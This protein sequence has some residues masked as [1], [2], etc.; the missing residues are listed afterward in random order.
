[1]KLSTTH[2]AAFGMLAAALIA[3]R[4]ALVVV[5]V[6]D[7]PLAQIPE[8]LGPWTCTEQEAPNA[9][10]TDETV[11]LRRVYEHEDGTLISAGFQITSSRLGA[12]RNWSVAQMGNGWN[13]EEPSIVGPIAVEGLPFDLRL[14]LQWLHRTGLRRL[15]ATWFVSPRSQAVEYERAQ[16]H[17]WWD[18][19][20]GKCVWGE[21]YMTTLDGDSA[22][23]LERATR[24]LATRLAPHFHAA[25]SGTAAATGATDLAMTDGGELDG[26]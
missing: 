14:K 25:L 22:A 6:S 16:M 21:L 18:K 11:Y 9:K 15:T 17:G 4:A 8:R 10:N 23:G 20:L 3:G 26:D 12:L 7:L 13:V 24:D 2:L 5:D 1:M 19:L